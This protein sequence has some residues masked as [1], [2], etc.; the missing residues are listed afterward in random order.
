M[1]Y[2]GHEGYV[3]MRDQWHFGK[4]PDVK[5]REKEEYT[6][7]MQQSKFALCPRGTGPSSLRIWEAFAAGVVPVIIAD[8]LCLP[9]GINWPECSIRL[10]ENEVKAIPEI[11][12]RI[13]DSDYLDMQ[14]K[15]KEVGSM[16]STDFCFPVRQW[17]TG[18]KL[19]IWMSDEERAV[20]EKY[21]APNHKCLEWGS[22]GSTIEFSK[23]V[24]HFVSIENDR[25]WHDKVCRL[26]PSHEIK[27]IETPYDG[28][29][30][31]PQ[32]F[33]DYIR[34]PSK[35]NTKFDR[36]LIDGRCRV[37][38]ARE[39]LE[40]ALLNPDGLVFIHDWNRKR[41]HQVLDCYSIVEEY[42]TEEEDSGGIVVLSP[43][44]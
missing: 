39:V 30:A 43:N 3:Q 17:L 33:H 42:V 29:E 34:F 31:C 23:L 19:E 16:M 40:K 14:E 9:T 38:C 28:G 24:R 44:C 10:A 35:L 20:V 6:R 41:Y 13:T 8:D 15:C 4:K 2:L 21:L 12:S 27:L 1:K 32:K 25:I 36:I 11:L 26:L 18:S 5:S 37:A 7:V 22:G